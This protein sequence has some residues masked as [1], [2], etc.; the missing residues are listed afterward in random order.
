MTGEK[1]IV[2]LWRDSAANQEADSKA[3]DHVATPEA[4]S[5]PETEAPAE[6]DWLDMS[7]LTDVEDASEDD[8]ADGVSPRR[9]DRL[10]PA[11]LM[12]VGAGWTLFAIYWQP[13][14]LFRRPRLAIGRP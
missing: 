6:R 8:G 4:A 10:A 13:M 9:H 3:P 14:P 7:S 1:K 12:L 11:L 5:A 2:G